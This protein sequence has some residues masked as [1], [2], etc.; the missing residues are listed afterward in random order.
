[1]DYTFFVA[2]LSSTT[3]IS[4]RHVLAVPTR[5]PGPA[6][7][8]VMMGA[9]VSATAFDDQQPNDSCAST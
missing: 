9:H 1:M 8:A 4:A 6:S 5:G 3:H 2:G 7:R